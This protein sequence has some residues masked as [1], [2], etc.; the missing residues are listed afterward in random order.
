MA[1]DNAMPRAKEAGAKQGG[2]GGVVDHGCRAG[3]IGSA[4]GTARSM[5]HR[6]AGA[7]G[8]GYDRDSGGRSSPHVPVVT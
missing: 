6:E 4:A 3:G 1:S 2:S 5:M 7:V 8:S